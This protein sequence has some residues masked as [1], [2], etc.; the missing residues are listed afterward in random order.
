MMC[1]ACYRLIGAVE[2]LGFLS[3]VIVV[4]VLA[5]TLRLIFSTLDES[6]NAIGA[7]LR[8]EPSRPPM[9]VPARRAAGR[10]IVVTRPAFALLRAA[11]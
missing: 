7:A 8:G 5:S 10:Q 2:M 11:A 1:E 6:S 4:A 9:L 3:F